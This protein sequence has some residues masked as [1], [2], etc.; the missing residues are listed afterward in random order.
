MPEAQIA[1]YANDE[2]SPA[3][4]WV[5][6]D[7]LFAGEVGVLRRA[8]QKVVVLRG[9]EYSRGVAE[10]LCSA[11]AIPFARSFEVGAA[12]EL[13]AQTLSKT[14][15]VEESTTIVAVGGGRV[16]DVAKFIASR[17][18][19]RLIVLPTLVA[20]DGVASPVAVLRNAQGYSISHGAKAPDQVIL[21]WSLLE[22]VPLKFWKALAGDLLGNLVAVRDYRRFGISTEDAKS[23][24]RVEK[25]CQDAEET[26]RCIFEHPNPDFTSKSFRMML[27]ENAIKSSLVMIAAGTSQPC[28]GS[29]HLLSHAIDHLQIS[30]DWLH[31][32]Q[33]GAAVPF[34]LLLHGDEALRAEVLELYRK[35]DMVASLQALGPKVEKQLREILDLAPEMRAGR[36]TVLDQFSTNELLRRITVK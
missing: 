5:G 36:H 34:C 30:Q 11:Y 27:V 8:G 33:V 23:V 18:S 22:P 21:C 24:L 20:T 1:S 19:K 12:S 15:A 13:V 16:Q 2:I 31:G 29:E 7:A 26:A 14:D 28:S 35:L 17:N 3:I 25:L 9:E 10:R 32:E 6:V 4:E